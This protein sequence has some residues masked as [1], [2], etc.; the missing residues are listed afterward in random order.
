M[1]SYLDWLAPRDRSVRRLAFS[2]VLAAGP[3]FALGC[4][5]G[6]K[7]ADE[8]V[9]QVAEGL[10]IG[11]SLYFKATGAAT[12]TAGEPP[13]AGQ[14]ELADSG[15][16]VCLTNL[17]AQDG[18]TGVT[19]PG[20]GTTI[21]DAS[22]QCLSVPLLNDAGTVVFD[23]TDTPELDNRA[24]VGWQECD[25]HGVCSHGEGQRNAF[26]T[27]PLVAAAGVAVA[28]NGCGAG[29]GS[30]ANFIGGYPPGLHRFGTAT[31]STSSAGSGSAAV[32]QP[33]NLYH[34]DYNAAFGGRSAG[35]APPLVLATPTLA[36]TPTT[37]RGVVDE[38]VSVVVGLGK[39]ISLAATGSAAAGGTSLTVTCS[40]E[41]GCVYQAE[42]TS[43]GHGL[44]CC[45]QYGCGDAGAPVE[46]QLT[47]HLGGPVDK[48][49]GG[50]DAGR[51][52][53]VVVAS[54]AFHG[55]SIHF[56]GDE[57]ALSSSEKV[58]GVTKEFTQPASAA[59]GSFASLSAHVCP[60]K[61]RCVP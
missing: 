23:C 27:G 40:G 16:V 30:T 39:N 60:S 19:I 32:K 4:T 43:I 42:V 41:S 22:T 24:Q 54:L 15:V 61:G 36:T 48:A 14:C 55:R 6:F 49:D 35:E 53:M 44:E 47:K 50:A 1:T 29:A 31:P 18:G 5:S 38:V 13:S 25:Q 59:V 46:C 11:D 34:Y 12:V 10:V 26:S 33:R 3:A 17:I 2:V 58:G 37:V 21:T 57:L 52:D 45:G 28:S 9:V 20:T 56:L 51:I 8:S 7:P